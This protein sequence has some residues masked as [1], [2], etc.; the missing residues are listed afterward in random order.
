MMCCNPPKNS[1][2]FLPVSLDKLFPTL[3]P[4]DNL[5]QF[6]L[7]QIASGVSLVGNANPQTFGFVV[8]DGPE[9][10]VSSLRRRDGSHLEF[11]SCEQDRGTERGV[12]QFV[13][14][15][16][17]ENSNCDDMRKNGL[18]GTI[19]R[20]PEECGF[21][22]YSVAHSVTASLDQNLPGH[23]L[24][25]APTDAVIY[26]LEYSYDF[27]LAKRD[28]GDIFIRVDYSDSHDYFDKIVAAEPDKGRKRDLQSRYWSPI[29]SS[30]KTCES[31]CA[32]VIPCLLWIVYDTIRSTENPDYSA[33]LAKE[34]FNVLLF[35]DD[36][37]KHDC[38]SSKD[39]FLKVSV[40]G[41]VKNK[42]KFGVTLVGT[43]APGLALEEAYSY[44]DSDLDLSGTLEFDGKGELNIDGGNPE[45]P[46]FSSPIT[47]YEFSH[48]GIVSFSPQLN[49]DVKILG[50]GQIDG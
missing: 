10:A 22:T 29:S 42:L 13:C 16:T 2:P 17:S 26:D 7:Q 45:K 36:G 37:S 32:L 46:L 50:R 27:K 1:N 33:S 6:D 14:M 19:L 41:S 8:I 24:E 38:S 40:S 47:N 39:G 18:A 35:G 25:R 4:V 21:A 15:D 44:F 30:W 49:V 31:S 5:P 28:A 43:I 11:L 20:M 23:L 9:D 48:P 3:P 34:D 12:A